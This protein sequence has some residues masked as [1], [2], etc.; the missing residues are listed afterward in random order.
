MSFE[1]LCVV[2][3]IADG[4]MAAFFVEG[5]EVLV[6]RDTSGELHAY[7]GLCPHEDFPLAYGE[8]DGDVLVCANH[9]WCFDATTGKG[10]NPPSCNLTP[11]PLRVE[12]D[13]VYV[14]ADPAPG[15]T[16]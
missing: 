5:T 12:G 1:R 15:P 2:G 4:A 13:A 9:A 6:V 7:D 3:D 10:V 14:D 8:L 16:V 11:Y